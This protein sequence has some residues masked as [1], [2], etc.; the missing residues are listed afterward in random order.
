LCTK[1]TPQKALKKIKTVTSHEGG[2]GLKIRQK[3]V[4]N[5]MNGPFLSL[6]QVK[7]EINLLSGIDVIELAVNIRKVSRPPRPI[8]YAGL[9]PSE[10]SNRF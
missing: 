7:T 9:W 3:S 5:Y 2:R 1:I 6:A 4:T 8:S 10:F